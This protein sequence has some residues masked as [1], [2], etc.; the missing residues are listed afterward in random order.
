L[1][2]KDEWYYK[3]VLIKEWILNFEDKK[4]SNEKNAKDKAQ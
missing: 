3:F 4:E 1:K 2:E